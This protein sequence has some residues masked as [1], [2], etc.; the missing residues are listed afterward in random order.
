MV[1]VSVSGSQRCRNQ[2]P[3]QIMTI[4]NAETVLSKN[5]PRTFELAIRLM[6]ASPIDFT[7]FPQTSCAAQS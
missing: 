1:D 7:R 5:R 4:A 3:V 2:G 6:I